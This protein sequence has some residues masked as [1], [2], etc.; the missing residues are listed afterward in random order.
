VSLFDDYGLS[1]P[2]VTRLPADAYRQEAG[3]CDGNPL[4]WR[5]TSRLCGGHQKLRHV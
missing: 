4:R 5:L 1:T 3:R 2:R